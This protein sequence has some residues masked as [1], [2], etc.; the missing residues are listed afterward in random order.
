ME[1]WGSCRFRQERGCLLSE[2]RYLLALGGLLHDIG[3]FALRAGEGGGRFWDDEAQQDFGY[4]HAALSADFLREYVPSPW[5]GGE[6]YRGAVLHHRPQGAAALAV[7][8]ADRLSAGEREKTKEAEPKYLRPILTRVAEG[9]PG[10]WY[11]PLAPLRME[12]RRI[13]PQGG[14]PGD[15]PEREYQ[16]LWDE[17][18][19]KAKELKGAFA[20]EGADLASYLVNLQGLLLRYTWCIPSAAYHAV[21]DVS[22]YDHCRMTA[23]L[24]ACL[25]EE[26]EATLE[27]LVRAPESEREVVL[28]I[29]GDISGV[30]DFIYTIT[31]RGALS[32]LRGRSFYLQLLTEATAAYLLRQ[33]GLPP[34]NLVYAGGGHFYL[35]APRTAG[36]EV[37]RVQREVSH[38][39]LRHHGG[40]LYLALAYRPLWGQEFFQGRLSEAWK[41]LGERLRQVKERRFAELRGEM[42]RLVFAVGKD[43]GNQERECQ[44]CHHEHSQTVE[45]H[46]G[47]DALAWRKCPPCRAFEGLGDDLRRARY[48][49]LEEIPPHEEASEAAGTYREVFE[50]LGLRVRLLERLPEEGRGEGALR[51]QLLAL[52]DQA[53][54]ALRP[55]PRLAVGRQ[56]LVNVTPIADGRV[57]SN[58]ALAKASRGIERLGILRMDV[59]NLG[60]LFGEGLGNLATLS[61][62]ASLSLSIRI[63]FEGWVEALAH[64][65]GYQ[66]SNSLYSIYSGGDDLFFVGA[67][68]ALVDLALRIADDFSAYTGH[69]PAVH[70]SGGLIL[71][72]AGYPLYLAAS[73]AAEAEEQAKG[74]EGKDA[75]S[76]LGRALKWSIFAQVAKETCMLDDW[77]KN[78]RAPRSLLRLLMRAQEAYEEVKERRRREGAEGAPQ[79][80]YGPW[81]PRLE[82]ALARLAEREKALAEDLRA[83]RDRLR[84]EDYRSIEWIGLAARW[85]ELLNRER[86]E[87]RG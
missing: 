65:V 42:H 66:R 85:A 61:R 57:A 15:Q 6:A 19:T 77:V 54:A 14:A 9:A 63:Y 59:D 11:A 24:A 39:L 31:P 62:V 55:A 37:A 22:L 3:K 50:A 87:K 28:L 18:T 46:E 49:Y 69:N 80:Y 30:Q 25:A 44:V 71:A 17:F 43:E 82:Y 40:D 72:E 73:E 86:K 51:A 83:L 35:L 52:D 45:V 41:D 70:L 29:G 7:A 5:G 79:G 53:F 2:R 27:A 68:D 34:T 64:Q 74:L 26:D 47:E 60:R 58:D 78:D 67:W 33:L 56:W 32:A 13:F 48:L 16:A 12:K 75:F 23:A 1:E 76:F 38:L 81:I 20:Q 8:V 36:T 21:P 4:K 84:S 10:E